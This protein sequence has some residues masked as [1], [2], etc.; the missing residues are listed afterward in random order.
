MEKASS[1]DAAIS[2]IKVQQSTVLLD[3]ECIVYSC[4][5]ESTPL[6]VVTQNSAQFAQQVSHLESG[7]ALYYPLSY[8]LPL[9]LS[10]RV[11]LLPHLEPL[12]PSLAT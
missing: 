5:L 2:I 6:H 10:L 8:F 9:F 1:D 4:R 7:T 12:P 3:N 11:L